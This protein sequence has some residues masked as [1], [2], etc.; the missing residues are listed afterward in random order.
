VDSAGKLTLTS[1]VAG[2]TLT[3]AGTVSDDRKSLTAATYTVTG[4]SCGFAAAQ[5]VAAREAGSTV[6]ARE[7]VST[8]TAQQYQPV[9]GTY[10]GTLTDSDGMQFTL[11]TTITETSQPDVNGVY[12][13]QGTASS[14]GNACIPTAVNATASTVTGSAVLTTYSDPT[15]GTTIDATGTSTPDGS[16][17]TV[18]N[19]NL[20]SNCGSDSGTGTLTRQ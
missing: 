1:S 15:T 3:I 16:K 14:P 4:G 6:T 12:H 17:L 10:L 2:G 20:V 13:I 11:S 7:P 5:T 8:V 9:S 19:W 18:T